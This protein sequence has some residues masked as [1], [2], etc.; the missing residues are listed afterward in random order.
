[1]SQIAHVKQMPVKK[2]LI[3]RSMGL[4]FNV[5]LLVLMFTC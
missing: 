2:Y 3:L 5:Y 1:M 4:K